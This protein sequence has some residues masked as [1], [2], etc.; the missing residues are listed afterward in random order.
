VFEFTAPHRITTPG[1]VNHFCRL[2][3]TSCVLR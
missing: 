2:L 1:C 3:K